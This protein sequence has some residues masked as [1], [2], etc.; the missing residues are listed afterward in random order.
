[1]HDD[2]VQSRSR[3]LH[4]AP[5]WLDAQ[6]IRAYAAFV[7]L[8]NIGYFSLRI[9]LGAIDP[10]PNVSPPGW[11]FAVFWSASWLALHGPAVNAFD[12][13]LI[14]P[15]ALP[16]QNML[17][18]AFV[19]PWTY[20]PTFLLV[21]LP[22]ALLPFQVSCVAYLLAGTAF[23]F[24]A[25]ARILPPV[26][27][28]SWWLPVVAFPA[29]WV[30]VGA[31]QNSFLTF[32]LMGLGLVCL[33][34]RPW[35]AGIL[36]GLLAIKP[37]LGLMIPVA[38]VFGRNWRAFI[39]AA[40]SVGVFCALSGFVL[41]FGTFARFAEALP[42]F[43]QFVV[44]Y[45]DRWPRGILT[46]FGTARHFGVAVPT[47]YLL[48]AI[49]AALAA[50]AVAW[51]WATRA[52]FELRASALVLATLLVPT[53]LMPYDLLL[54]GL[55]ILWLVRDGTRNGWIRGDAVAMVSAWLSPVVSYTPGGWAAGAY[56][57]FIVFALLL[58]VM[59]RYVVQRAV[60]ANTC[61]CMV[62][63]EEHSSTVSRL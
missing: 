16:L 19:T 5:R 59:R 7:L 51:L 52:S 15:I 17:P 8:V 28:L 60:S 24:K 49:M 10:V 26:R 11:D 33:E 55:P 14:E 57:P 21:M 63:A 53:Y 38:L 4:R 13:A 18:S 9:W 31:G 30:T 3:L 43:S 62:E 25:C 56:V 20:P 58:V 46:V 12:T 50:S 39:S 22:A 35:L 41:G 42:A 27:D 61:A 40:L 37:Q 6:R 1:M 2:F 32:A 34:R 23:A 48:H 44:Q 47:A 29:I 54:L 36:F 45:S